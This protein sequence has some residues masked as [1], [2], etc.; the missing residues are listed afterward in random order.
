MGVRRQTISVRAGSTPAAPVEI[1]M[2]KLETRINNNST[3]EEVVRW[4]LLCVIK[5]PHCAWKKIYISRI[6]VGDEQW[7]EALHVFAPLIDRR[8]GEIVLTDELH[9]FV[10]EI[11]MAGFA[12]QPI[13]ETINS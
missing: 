5:N 12:I 2:L 6:P 9:D 7:G 4:S 3:D 1:D 10:N 11:N 13:E 8:D